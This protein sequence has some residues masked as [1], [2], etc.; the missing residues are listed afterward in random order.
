VA[1][2]KSAS[3]SLQVATL[4]LTVARA[5]I[6]LPVPLNDAS[7][8]IGTLAQDDLALDVVGA[9]ADRLRLPHGCIW[10]THFRKRMTRSVLV[11]HEAMV[12]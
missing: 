2:Q 11:L 7:V 5:A 8:G 9:E 10:A 12:R 6:G 3:I 4:I 1:V